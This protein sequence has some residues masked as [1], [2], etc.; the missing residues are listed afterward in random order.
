MVARR[1]DLVG[2][3]GWPRLLSSE[4]AGAYLGISAPM[5]D[6][7]GLTAH[8]IGGR[9]LYDRCELDRWVDQQAFAANDDFD[10]ALGRLGR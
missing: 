5:L 9:K 3:P 8:R 7:I 6:R 1:E 2:L 4:Q 10:V